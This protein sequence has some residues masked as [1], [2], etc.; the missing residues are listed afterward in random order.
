MSLQDTERPS[1]ASGKLKHAW[2][3]TRLN[4]GS[5][6]TPNT[7]TPL[8]RLRTSRVQASKLRGL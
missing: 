3:S 6:Q 8:N 1:I 4:R 5:L 2:L 7:K